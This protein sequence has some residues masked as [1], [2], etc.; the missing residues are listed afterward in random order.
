MSDMEYRCFRCGYEWHGR[1]KRTEEGLIK[2][3]PRVCPNCHSPWWDK[4]RRSEDGHS[5]R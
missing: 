2:E 5:Q 3:K 4:E 1:A